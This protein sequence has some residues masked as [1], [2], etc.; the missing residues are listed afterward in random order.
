MLNSKMNA[1]E[2]LRIDT[3]E[4]SDQEVIG[5][6]RVL[7]DFD[8]LEQEAI[9]WGNFRV[10]LAVSKEKYPWNKENDAPDGY[11]YVAHLVREGFIEDVPTR[12]MHV[13]KW[14]EIR[15][16]FYPSRDGGLDEE[17]NYYRTYDDALVAAHIPSLTNRKE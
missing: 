16:E 17:G 14:G 4:Y 11:S 13:A 8:I 1:G 10:P 7:K 6:F 9:A 15:P 12:V 3:G 5:T 2:L